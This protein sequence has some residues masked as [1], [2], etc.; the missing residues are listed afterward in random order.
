MQIISKKLIVG[1]G[2]VA[3]NGAVAVFIV[4][5]RLVGL[6]CVVR[7]NSLI[8]FGVSVG[9]ILAVNYPCSDPVGGVVIID[10]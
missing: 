5:I 8:G 3:W 1:S 2:D 10:V 9:G 7:G 4:S 6:G